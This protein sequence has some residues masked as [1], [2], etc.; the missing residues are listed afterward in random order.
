MTQLNQFPEDMYDLSCAT[1]H[2]QGMSCHMTDKGERESLF[3]K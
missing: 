1:V 3:A 2:V